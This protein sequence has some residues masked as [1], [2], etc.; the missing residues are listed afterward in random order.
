M[1]NKQTIYHF[2]V[3]KSGSMSGMEAQT[4]DGFNKQLSALQ[5]LKKEFPE[6]DYRVSLTLFNGEVSDVVLFG[7]VETWLHSTEHLTVRKVPPHYWMRLEN[8]STRSSSNLVTLYKTMRQ[9]W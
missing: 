4:I 1:K 7:N 6:Q 8:R 9:V 2:V 3:D 5:A